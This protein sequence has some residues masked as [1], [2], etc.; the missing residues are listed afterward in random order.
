MITDR[1]VE[2]RNLWRRYHALVGEL[3]SSDLT[4]LR[5]LLTTIP[6]TYDEALQASPQQ[7]A[8]G[9]FSMHSG[10]GMLERDLVREWRRRASEQITQADKA[11]LRLESQ[12]SE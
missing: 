1:L 2:R 10:A 3:P 4:A 11:L 12:V 5:S 9:Q 6:V 7:Q 8:E